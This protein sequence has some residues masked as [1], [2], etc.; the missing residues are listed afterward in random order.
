MGVAALKEMGNPEGLKMGAG[1]GAWLA[2]AVSVVAC[3]CGWALARK[4]K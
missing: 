2:L 1:I 4:D 3:G